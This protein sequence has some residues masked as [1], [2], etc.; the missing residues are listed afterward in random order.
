[1]ATYE[2]TLMH[3]ERGGEG[4]YKFDAEDGLMGGSAMTVVRTFMEHLQDHAGIDHIDWQVN[5]AMKN[6]DKGV[7]TALGNLIM[8][9]DDEQPFV[10]FINAA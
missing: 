7:V 3:G 2:A 10:C 5:A 4:R 6:K 9:D 8:N 1:M